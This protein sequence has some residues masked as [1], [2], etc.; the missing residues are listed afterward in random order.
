[1][2]LVSVAL[3]NSMGKKPRCIFSPRKSLEQ[4]MDVLKERISPTLAFEPNQGHS[5]KPTVKKI[6]K[7][8]K[9]QSSDL[10]FM[11]K[12]SGRLNI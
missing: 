8:K 10:N 2:N 3:Q 6:R 11:N 4:V 9:Q 5:D 1:M 7:G 12:R